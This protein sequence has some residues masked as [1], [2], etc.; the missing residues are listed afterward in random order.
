MT[1]NPYGLG[2]LHTVSE[3]AFTHGSSKTFWTFFL[4][5]DIMQRFVLKQSN[6]YHFSMLS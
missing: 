2:H 3:Y 1:F 6:K 4:R 5:D